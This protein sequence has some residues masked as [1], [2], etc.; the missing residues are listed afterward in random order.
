M[1]RVNWGKWVSCATVGSDGDWREWEDSYFLKGTATTL[2]SSYF[3]LWD[4]AEP[5]CQVFQFSGKD[6]GNWILKPNDKR[7]HHVGFIYIYMS[8]LTHKTPICAI[9]L[10]QWSITI[11]DGKI[12]PHSIFFFTKL[13]IYLF[14]Y[15]FIYLFFWLLWVFV[16]ACGLSLVAVSGDYSSLRCAGF[17]L[18]WLLLLWSTGSRPPGFSSCGLRALEHR[19]SSCGA[20]A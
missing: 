7:K 18:W 3:L 6:A 8:N 12:G 15:L 9:W 10:I 20:R 11:S 5:G 1:M 16:A 4:N 19:L 2:S 13:F 14:M 17:S